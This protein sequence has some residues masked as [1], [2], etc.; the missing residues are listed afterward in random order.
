MAKITRLTGRT[1]WID[2]SFVER[3]RTPRE[4]IEVGIRL[5]LSG[6]S[7]SDTVSYLETLGVERSRTAVH[8]WVHKA[9]L[10]PDS[11]RC[12]NHLALDETVIRVNGNRFWLYAAVDAV[13]N[14]ILLC[15]LYPAAAVE[16]T[17]QFLRKLQSKYGLDDVVF[18]VDNAHHLRQ[19]LDRFGLRFQTRRYG[20]R[21]AVERVFREL[22]RRTSS[23][24]N[25]FRNAAPSTAES[26]LQA[27]AVCHNAR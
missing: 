17:L 14:N 12:S 7:L 3:E 27:L 4:L 16:P 1:E 26:W 13:S 19:M 25:C 11:G 20:N 5:H 2:L 6:L 8:N 15:E 22:K 23:F 9:D 18:Y 10:Q 21:N 24:A